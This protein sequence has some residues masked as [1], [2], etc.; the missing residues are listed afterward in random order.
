MQKADETTV[1][2][3]IYNKTF[4]YQGVITRF[5]RDNDRYMIHT[6]G[7]EKLDYHDALYWT[8]FSQ[9]W[10]SQCAACHSTAIKGKYDATTRSFNTTW[11]EIDVGC[12]ACHGPGDRHFALVKKHKADSIAPEIT[13][14]FPVRLEHQNEVHWQVD[15]YGMTKQ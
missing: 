4:S 14:G 11:S 1:L 13:S 2:G 12:E 6:D 3:D 5:Y 9:N 15:Q 8:G 10:N 7:D